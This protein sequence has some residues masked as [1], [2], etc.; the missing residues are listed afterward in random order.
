MFSPRW[1]ARTPPTGRGCR[2]CGQGR[3]VSAARRAP[4]L[5]ARGAAPAC[6]RPSFLRVAPVAESPRKAVGG[7]RCPVDGDG[8]PWRYRLRRAA[9]SAPDGRGDQDGRREDADDAAESDG[10]RRVPLR[11]G[12]RCRAQL[13]VDGRRAGLGACRRRARCRGPG[14]RGSGGRHWR[15]TWSRRTSTPGPGRARAVHGGW[16]KMS[17][18]RRRAASGGA[19]R[20]R[21][22]RAFRR[23]TAIAAPWI[24]GCDGTLG[25]P[26]DAGSVGY[27]AVGVKTCAGVRAGAGR[28][29]GVA[30]GTRRESGGSA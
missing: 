11:R 1:I 29:G 17:P 5:T 27:L 21:R 9:G 23:G 8:R 7:G 10:P 22:C 18:G 26:G 13:A 16:R 30:A 3:R 25:R 14:G 15:R 28:L 19:I 24:G 6:L 4:A 2:A 20:G 12:G